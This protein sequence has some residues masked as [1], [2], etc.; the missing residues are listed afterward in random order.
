[1]QRHDGG[2][3]SSVGESGRENPEQMMSQSWHCLVLVVPRG[4]DADRVGA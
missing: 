3:V 2:S 4:V 1:M